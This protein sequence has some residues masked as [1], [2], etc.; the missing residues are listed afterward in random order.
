M[1][2][3]DAQT[4]LAHLKRDT[5]KILPIR[6]MRAKA[7]KADGV[8]DVCHGQCLEDDEKHLPSEWQ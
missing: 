8:S 6:G 7:K 4:S 3:K 5:N 2:S 1:E